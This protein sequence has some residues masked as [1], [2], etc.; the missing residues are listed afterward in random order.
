MHPKLQELADAMRTF[1]G[2]YPEDSC[3]V[4]ADRTH[5]LDYAPGQTVDIHL[6]IGT[7]IEQMRGTVTEKALAN[8]M[9]LQEERGPE[10][11]GFS[12]IST[13]VPVHDENGALIGAVAAVTSTARNDALRSSASD[14]SAL[15]EQLS[16]ATDE[17]ANGSLLI[18]ENSLSSSSLSGKME[19]SINQVSEIIEFVEEIATRSNL[20]GLN[21]AIE[22]ARAG[23]GGRGFAVLADE[24]RKMA[25]QSKKA[26]KDIKKQLGAITEGIH[27][28]NQASHEIAATTQQH[29]AGVEELKALYSH[30]ANMAEKLSSDADFTNA[31]AAGN[32]V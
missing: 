9:R 7:A 4:L 26:A 12:Y 16:Q 31:K 10:R 30:I 18:A 24:I 15:V 22:A 21:A 29:S 17:I 2:T 32:T 27:Q 28:L 23:E 8:N 19:T 25:D 14:L 1:Q 11:F 20:L 5:V 3:M 6:Q 13:A